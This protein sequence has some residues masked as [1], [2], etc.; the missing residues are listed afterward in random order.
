MAV[1]KNIQRINERIA[2][3]VSK[4]Q[5]TRERIQH[6]KDRIPV[7]ATSIQ[8]KRGRVQNITS[9]IEQIDID[10]EALENNNGSEEDIQALKDERLAKKTTRTR[11]KADIAELL[12]ELEEL[13][14]ERVHQSLRE[15]N[16]MERVRYLKAKKYE[17]T[18]TKKSPHYK[19]VSYILDAIDDIE[20]VKENLKQ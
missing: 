4:I 16:M 9:D 12:V 19:F 11:I 7:V 20:A 10:I 1:S 18:K 14:A 5:T 13:K 17:Y 3:V 8:N 6:L 2:V 15:N